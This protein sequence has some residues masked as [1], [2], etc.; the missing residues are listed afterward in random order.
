MKLKFVSSAILLFFFL[1]YMSCGK[2]NA[3][4]N[5]SF[6]NATAHD[7]TTSLEFAAAAGSLHNSGLEN[8][9]LNFDF[10]QSFESNSELADSLLYNLSNF[11]E[12]TEELDFST[13]YEQMARDSL[14]ERFDSEILGDISKHLAYLNWVRHTSVITSNLSTAELNFIDSL[15]VFFS[16][17]VSGL[18][19]S[20]I[21]VLS[22]NK[23]QSLLST[24]NQITWSIGQ[25]TLAIGALN[26][27]KSTSL[28]WAS[29]DRT[30]FIGFSGG[31]GYTPT[32]AWTIL[33][34]DC[35]G[36]IGG[37]VS[38]LIDDANGGGVTPAGQDRRIQQG[39]NAAAC[40]SGGA[41][42]F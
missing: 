40:A 6:S 35:L 4:S 37:W 31:S 18:S 34:I 3:F 33:Q 2:E 24:F 15:V 14:A 41:I 22:Y 12:D 26:V 1:T 20:Q 39:F 5:P 25:G 38:A 28:Y 29:H 16:T 42:L 17:N 23:S 19:K 36:Y 9:R 11:F 10:T 13:S 21:C 8:L 27:L 30:G 7:R 32:Q